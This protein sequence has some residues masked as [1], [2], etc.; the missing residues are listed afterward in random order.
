VHAYAKQVRKDSRRPERWQG[1]LTKGRPSRPVDKSRSRSPEGLCT[2]DYDPT[3]Y[4]VHGSLIEPL[5]AVKPR[6]SHRRSRWRPR[7]RRQ[8][9]Q[10]KKKN[11]AMNDWGLVDARRA[12]RRF[13]DQ[14]TRSASRRAR[15][16]DTVTTTTNF[17][18][19]RRRPGRM[20]TRLVELQ[21]RRAP[22][23]R[24]CPWDGEPDRAHDRSRHRR[25]RAYEVRTPRFAGY[26]PKAP[27]R[28]R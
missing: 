28:D 17:H 14:S 18:V 19:D 23:A 9:L 2:R 7:S 15:T 24:E 13:A 26:D 3:Q 11:Q 1:H 4:K 25:G 12:L 27:R 21:E 6:Q 20:K 5:T 16:P 22:C 8:L 10:T